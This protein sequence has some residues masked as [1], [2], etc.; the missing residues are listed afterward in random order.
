[1]EGS[2]ELLPVIVRRLDEP[3]G[4]SSL[5]PT[6]LLCRM[7]RRYVTVALGGDGGDELFAGYDPFRALTYARLYE[8]LVPRPVHAAIRLAA[9]RLPTSLANLS[10]DF[11]IKRALRGLS[12]P[13]FLWNSVWLGPLEPRELDELFGEPTDLEEIYEEA[14][15]SWDNCRQGSLVDRTLQFYVNLYLQDDI[16]VKA[17]RASMMNSLEVRSPYLDIDLVDFVRRIPSAYKFR[18]G[19]TKYLLK[20]SLEPVLPRENLYRAKK[21]FGVPIGRWIRDGYLAFA[22]Y[23]ADGLL[24]P[25]FIHRQLAQHRQGRA[26]HRAFLWNA[27]LLA[28]WSDGRL[29]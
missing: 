21:G 7:A 20:K 18:R 12:Y 11:K 2:R 16:L 22:P 29:D 10:L 6:Y 27:W 4:D 23:A 17:D 13:R 19:E 8:K 15:A 3:M 5:L 14:I 26:D 25:G 28:A 1:M 9:A 24:N